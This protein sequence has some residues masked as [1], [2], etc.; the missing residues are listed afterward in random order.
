MQKL[1]ETFVEACLNMADAEKSKITDFERQLYGQS[2]GKIKTLLNKY[3]CISL[4]NVK[5]G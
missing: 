4:I 2:S 5:S 1:S 3:G